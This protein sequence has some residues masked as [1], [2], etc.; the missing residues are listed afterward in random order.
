MYVSG[1]TE[2]KAV[3]PIARDI[4]LNHVLTHHPRVLDDCRKRTSLLFPSLS[5]S[6]NICRE[7]PHKRSGRYYFHISQP[8]SLSISS[9]PL[10]T[11]DTLDTPDR[12]VLT[13]SIFVCTHVN[14]ALTTTVVGCLKVSR[15]C[16]TFCLGVI[17]HLPL[18]V[19]QQRQPFC[20]C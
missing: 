12:F 14:S 6:P 1:V 8:L 13:Y 17:R 15:H 7:I 9:L 18:T 5:T 4:H 20:G 11:L 19:T 2:Q 16:H 10:D 3:Q